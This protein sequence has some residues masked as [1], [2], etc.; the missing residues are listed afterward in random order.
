MGRFFVYE[1]TDPRDDR[2]FYVG[3]GCG[4]R[5][6]AHLREAQRGKRS[7]KCSRIREI[8]AEGLAVGI[9]VVER[10]DL[11]DAAYAAEVERI[12][13]I[14]LANLTN[15]LPGGRGGMALAVRMAEELPRS[16]VLAVAKLFALAEAG[17][18]VRWG[19]MDVTAFARESLERWVDRLGLEAVED[20]FR[21]A[22]LVLLTE[23][24]NAVR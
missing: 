19:G 5:P 14:G 16:A 4:N 13:E 15:V 11:E 3:K 18:R 23:Q 8:E 20:R 24:N 2:P 21:A 1:L 10:F 7:R 17:L 9:R 22:G 12:A 6:K